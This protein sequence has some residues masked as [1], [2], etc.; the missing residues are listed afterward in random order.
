ML[1]FQQVNIPRLIRS[2]TQYL[3]EEKYQRV[4]KIN[5]VHKKSI[6]AAIHAGCLPILTSMAE[7]V[8]L[9]VLKICI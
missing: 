1:Y 9:L 6:E 7:S 2:W 5:H 3:D 4:G 8:R